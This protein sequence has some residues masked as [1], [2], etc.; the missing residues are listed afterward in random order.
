MQYLTL[1]SFLAGAVGM[2]EVLIEGIK[3]TS[4]F[5]LYSDVNF[6]KVEVNIET[7]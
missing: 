1:L 7:Y 6:I 3:V 4:H 2:Q 5:S